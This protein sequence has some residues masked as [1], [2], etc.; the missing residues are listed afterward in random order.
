M[1]SSKQ[2]SSVSVELAVL[3][4]FPLVYEESNT[5][6]AIELFR[7]ISTIALG[8]GFAFM[9]AS[10]ESNGALKLFTSFFSNM[11]TKHMMY[12]QNENRNYTIGK[13]KN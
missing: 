1:I 3:Y 9:P 11:F 6:Y 2:V 8:F 12:Q 5:F 10:N 4:P 13:P 7:F